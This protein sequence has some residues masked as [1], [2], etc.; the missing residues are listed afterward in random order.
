MIRMIRITFSLFLLVMAANS[1][2]VAQDGSN[3]PI[4]APISREEPAP[5][6]PPEEWPQPFRPSQEISADAQVS[7]PTDI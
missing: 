4:P 1:A 6:K 7:F 2:V 5:A 3:Q